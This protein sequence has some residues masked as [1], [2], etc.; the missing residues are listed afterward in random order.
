MKPEK[1]IEITCPICEASYDV[2]EDAEMIECVC[3][4]IL[5]LKE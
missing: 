5:G 4:H 1:C 2:S 3:G